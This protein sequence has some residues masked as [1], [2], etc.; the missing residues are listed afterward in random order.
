MQQINQT[1]FNL[2]EASQFREQKKLGSGCIHILPRP[3]PKSLLGT[4][5]QQTHEHA[6]F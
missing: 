6:Q 1:C 5:I 3:K 4:S 2:E